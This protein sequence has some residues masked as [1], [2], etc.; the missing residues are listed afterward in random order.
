MRV[1]DGSVRECRYEAATLQCTHE[2][3][4]PTSEAVV[5]IQDS[6][7]YHK[8]GNP[9]DS[10]GAVTLHLYSPPFAHCRAWQED[11]TEVVSSVR[12]HSLYGALVEE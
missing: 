9:D 4:Y 1:L 8:V 3:T 10:V 5:F 6:L 11:G 12:Y 7:G 2:T